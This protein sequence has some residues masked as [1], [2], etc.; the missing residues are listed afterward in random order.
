MIRLLRQWVVRRLGIRSDAAA[1][2]EWWEIDL[3]IA[4]L[5]AIFVA[6]GMAL[7]A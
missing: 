6:G 7:L 4:F 5:F 3:I 1:N 2:E